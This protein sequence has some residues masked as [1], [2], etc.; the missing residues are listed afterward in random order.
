MRFL[1]FGSKTSVPCWSV[2]GHSRILRL[3]LRLPSESPP[4]I[5]ME[6]NPKQKLFKIPSTYF[7]LVLRIRIRTIRGSWTLIGI[8]PR[9]GTV[10]FCRPAV[11]ISHHF[12]EDADPCCSWTCRVYQ[13]LLCCS[14]TCLSTNSFCAAPGRFC[15]PKAFAMLLDVSVYQ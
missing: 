8:N 6:T 4:H 13:K 2:T 9:N 10:G 5:P 11:T 12:D 3:T 15:P 14:W 1:L 7:S